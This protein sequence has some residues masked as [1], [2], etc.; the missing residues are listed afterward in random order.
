MELL[1]EL[2]LD[3]LQGARCG[4]GTTAAGALVMDLH[5]VSL[6]AFHFHPAPVL[7]QVGTDGPVQNHFNGIYFFLVRHAGEF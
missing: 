7:G 6:D 1:F 2:G 4:G 5:V 3:V